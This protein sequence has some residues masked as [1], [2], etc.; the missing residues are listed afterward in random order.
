M[1]MKSE[2]MRRA[3]SKNTTQDQ[4]YSMTETIKNLGYKM[5][6][7]EDSLT[8]IANFIS[9]DVDTRMIPVLSKE[10]LEMISKVL[11]DYHDMIEKAKPICKLSG[12]NGNV[13]NI[14]GI[15]CNALRKEGLYD[16]AKE[17]QD[18]AFKAESYDSVLLMC[19]E[20]VRVK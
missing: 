16:N 11:T 8:A 15:V 5:K 3:L 7:E 20:Y 17:F 9:F 6:E 10:S 19:F 14:I 13:F 12:Q 18:K 4:I 1:T 2:I